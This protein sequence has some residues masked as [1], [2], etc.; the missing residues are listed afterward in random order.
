MTS[1]PICAATQSVLFL[2]A[3]EHAS[4]DWFEVCRCAQ[5]GVVFTNPPANLGRYYHSYYRRYRPWVHTLLRFIYRFY[6]RRWAREF[7]PP[8]HA[9]EI[10]CGE[11]WTLDAL[12]HEGWQVVGTERAPE[13]ARFAANEQQ[14]PVIVGDPDALRLRPMFD[15]ILMHHVLEHLPN[16]MTKLQ[17]C[18]TLLKASGTLLIVV[19]NLASWQFRA[20]KQHWFHLDVPRHLTHFTPG[21]LR[22]AL[23]RAGLRV[24]SIRYTSL[25]QDAFGWMVSLLNYL[26]FPQTRWLHWL[27]GRDCKLTLT[28][29][30]MLLLS[31]SL[32][33]IGFVLAAL[34]R[35]FRAGACMEVRARRD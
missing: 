17:Q 27:A 10:G 29:A 20:S 24:D 9:L 28:N 19:P 23:A 30:L 4:G 7:G 14:L 25:D 3:R 8:G 16:P 33:I 13:S 6:S 26:G 12:R 22:E 35:L 1:C 34:S 15:L 31:P 18:A 5:C 32:L 11:G 2:R 21:S